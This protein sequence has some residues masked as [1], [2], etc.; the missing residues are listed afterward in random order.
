[1]VLTI[2]TGRR[3]LV[4][5]HELARG[6]FG[7][8]KLGVWQRSADGSHVY[9]SLWIADAETFETAEAAEAAGV[10]LAKL[11]IDDGLL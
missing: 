5:A 6:G 10:Q 3:I 7:I 4:K 11:A 9:V 1:M 8:A 2:Y